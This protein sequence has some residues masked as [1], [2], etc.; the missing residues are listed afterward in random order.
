MPDRY[1]SWSELIEEQTLGTDFSVC[2]EVRGGA[3]WLV[4]APHGGGIE[5]GTTEI[6]RAVA[7][8]DLSFY[9]VEG[10][11]RTGNAVLH[12]TSHRFDEPS[13][14]VAASQHDAVATIHG[15]RESE[16]GRDVLVWVGG[17]DDAL[18]ELAIQRLSATEY[19]AAQDRFTPGAESRNVCNR[20]RCR[21]GLQLEL[22]ESLRERFFRDLTRVGRQHPTPALDQFAAVIRTIL[23]IVYRRTDS[24]AP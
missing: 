4:A 22:S 1:G 23:G 15:C 14:D 20:G 24:R 21:K 17:A 16:R 5:P 7:S 8:H 3:R 13:F 12:I 2:V 9:S 11:K 6:A 19:P 18:A 10:T